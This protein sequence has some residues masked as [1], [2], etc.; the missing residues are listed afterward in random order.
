MF[1]V[2]HLPL[3]LPYSISAVLYGTAYVWGSS[4]W[5]GWIVPAAL[6]LGM[7]GSMALRNRALLV[8]FIGVGVAVAGFAPVTVLTEQAFRLW[9]SYPD[10][11]HLMVLMVG[12][13]GCLAAVAVVAIV[14]ALL[15]P[16]L[17]MARSIPMAMALM[18][19]SLPVALHQGSEALWLAGLLVFGLAAVTTAVSVLSPM[20]PYAAVVG[21]SLARWT[22]LQPDADAAF[23]T[24][25]ALAVACLVEPWL[26][27]RRGV[28]KVL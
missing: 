3:A 28:P 6:G 19:L 23:W 14:V 15:V 21:A 22:A 8:H 1:H 13:A 2:K 17:P 25:L 7:L 26:L 24:L 5:M 18:A 10:A 4:A 20:A 27:M 11:S 16:D 9:R 12:V